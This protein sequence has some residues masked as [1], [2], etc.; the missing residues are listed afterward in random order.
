MT[1]TALND[2]AIQG[3]EGYL[4]AAITLAALSGGMLSLAGILRLGFLSSLLSYPVVSGFITA[5]AIVIALLGVAIYLLVDNINQGKELQA[6]K[7][8]LED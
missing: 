3:D 1:A 4:A 6:E 5:S 2:V 8:K 7:V